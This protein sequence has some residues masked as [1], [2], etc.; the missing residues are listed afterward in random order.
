MTYSLWFKIDIESRSDVEEVD[1]LRD[2]DPNKMGSTI[3][4][5]IQMKSR[6]H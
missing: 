6:K 1:S 5:V 2:R 4:G 3:E